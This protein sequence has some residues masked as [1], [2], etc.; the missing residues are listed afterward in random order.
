MWIIVNAKIC[1]VSLFIISPI[2]EE[3]PIPRYSSELK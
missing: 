2:H 3:V 1:T